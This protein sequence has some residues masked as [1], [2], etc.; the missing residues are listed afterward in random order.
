T[1]NGK[2]PPVLVTLDIAKASIRVIP[3]IENV[4]PGQVQFLPEQHDGAWRIVFTGYKHDVRKHG[5]V[6]CQNRP[7]ALFI[8][9]LDGA[10]VDKIAE[11]SVRSPRVMPSGKGIVYICTPLGG[12]HAATSEFCMYDFAS[13]LTT[14]LV[15]IINRPLDKAQTINGTQL[16][17][18][19]V[20]L[21]I[22]QLP[23]DPWAD[24]EHTD[25][26]DVMVFASTWRS[27]HAVLSLDVQNRKLTRHS[28]VDGTAS[29]SVISVS[30]DLVV[31]TKST[32]AQPAALVLGR[33]SQ[34]TDAA[35]I[36]IQWHDIGK[37][38]DTGLEWSIIP[39]DRDSC[40]SIFVHPAKHSSATR[41]FWTDDK[42]GSRPLVVQPH[43]GPHS[44]YTLDFSPTAAALAQLGFGVLLVNFTGSLGFGQDAVL[45]QIGQCDTLSLN[46]IQH[47]ARAVQCS[48][49]GDPASTV[50]V[51]GSYSGYTGA[52]LAGTAPGFYRGIALRNPV[53]S[54]GENAAM[55]DIPD[56]CWA[57]LG[58]E[59]DFANPPE[60]TPQAFAKMWDASPSRFVDKVVDPMLLLLGAS[61]RRVPHQQSL[62]YY[63]RLKAAAKANVQC[64]IYPDVGHPLDTVEAERDSFV[65]IARFFAKSLGK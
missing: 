54:I 63:Y 13:K 8:S 3:S 53:I 21:Y 59:Y 4:S 52:L 17:E 29:Y 35:Q 1:F 42:P 24:P 43:G 64:K 30:G 15:P 50:Y 41:Y 31:G 47:A 58:L 37:P 25:G 18:G 49:G 36:A 5:I 2:R 48:G 7:T 45:A 14:P 44:T 38:H 20:G 55:T 28:P 62:N 56:W 40:E 60:I 34:P 16:P 12:P 11:G 39:G 6:Y 23:L 26:R 57:E 10:N 33:I 51:G 61:D 9:D 46:E 32:P 65:S 19:F 27:T 22:D